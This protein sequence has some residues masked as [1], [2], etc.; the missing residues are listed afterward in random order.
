M[1]RLKLFLNKLVGLTGY[2][3]VRFDRSGYT[4]RDDM[5]ARVN[6]R[7]SAGIR[8]K[9]LDIGSSYG[10]WAK[11]SFSKS[12]EVV[13]MDARPGSD[14]QGDIMKMPFADGSFD[15]VF[16]FETIEHV[17][18]PFLAVSE[19]RRV[20]KPGGIFIGSTPFMHELHGEEYGDY[21]RPTRQAWKML[22]QDFKDVEVSSFGPKEL[23]P[24]HY[25]VKGIK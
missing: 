13:S 12:A 23:E 10:S 8:G 20:L 9:I 14:I 19:I 5:Y 3:I 17:K 7:Y 11:E 6:D 4:F 2:R 15:C 25:L 1:Q 16:C 22:L 18:N 24:H 21:W